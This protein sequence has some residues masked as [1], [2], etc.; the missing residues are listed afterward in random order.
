MQ[1]M[2][3][4]YRQQGHTPSG[5]PYLWLSMGF[6]VVVHFWETY[7]DARQYFRVAERGHLVPGALKELV[8]RIDA[9][10]L[11]KLEE[12]GTASRA[13]AM[14]KSKFK[15]VSATYGFLQSS[16]LAMVGAHAWAWDLSASVFEGEIPRSLVYMGL[17]ILFDAFTSLPFEAY[18]TFVVEQKHG[19]NKS[20]PTLFLADKVKSLALTGVLGGPVLAGLLTIIKKVGPRFLAIYVGGFVL[21]VSLFFLTIFPVFIQPLFNKYEPLEAGELRTAIEALAKSVNYPLY[22]LFTVDGSRRSSHSNAYMYGFFKFKRIVIFDTLLKQ[23]NTEEIVAILG[24]ELGHWAHAHTLLGFV[25]TQCYTLLAFTAFAHTMGHADLYR[26]FGFAASSSSS[27]SHTA[28]APTV[29]GLVLF[30]TTIWEPAD[31]LLNFLLVLNSR[32]MERQADKYAT[33]L[34]MHE[35]L[36]RGLVKI[37]HENLGVLDPDPWYSTYHHSHPTLFER[38]QAIDNLAKTK[39]A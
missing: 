5:V 33:D 19:F 8:T 24:H 26:S 38:I 6:S 2:L 35:P 4:W 3:P 18:S 31:H 15:V 22:K 37:T 11:T 16:A 17:W 27:S 12:K 7:L 10:L 36:Q 13:Y 1:H 23:A 20:T 29:I 32:R 30:F 34:G 28:G 9:E 14:T 39:T 21:F 25:V